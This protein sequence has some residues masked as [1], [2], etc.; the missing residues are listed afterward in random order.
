[1]TLAIDI[2]ATVVDSLGRLVVR[3]C[4]YSEELSVRREEWETPP[5][6]TGVDL[7]AEHT[8]RGSGL[9][10]HSCSFCFGGAFD[11]GGMVAHRKDRMLG[12][13]LVTGPV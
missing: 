9:F 12:L 10:S 2:R 13:R 11:L 8:A 4:C 6:G 3:R 1:M 7:Y 5:G